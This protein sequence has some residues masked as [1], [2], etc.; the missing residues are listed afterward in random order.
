MA[1]PIIA[2]LISLIPQAITTISSIVKDKKE[3]KE[4]NTPPVPPTPA[5]AIVDSMKEMVS[6]SIS[7]KRLLNIGGSGLIISLAMSN[8][9]TNG[10][11]KQNLA[12]IA[13]GVTYSLGMSLITWLSERK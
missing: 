2:G 5:G 7:S 9:S 3:K 13:I 6:G 12:L 4:V 1:A 8:I 11:T 10:L